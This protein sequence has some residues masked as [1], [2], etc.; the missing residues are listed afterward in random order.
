MRDWPMPETDEILVS[1]LKDKRKESLK[2][3][4]MHSRARGQSGSKKPL[5]QVKHS[6][7]IHDAKEAEQLVVKLA[8]SGTK[9]SEI[10][11][12]LRDSYGI[13]DVKTITNKKVGDILKEN[14]LVKEIPE[15]LLCVIRRDIV[16]M[17]HLDANKKDLSAKRGMI[18]TESKIHRL[19]KYYIREGKLPKDWKYDRTKA[20]VL[21][22]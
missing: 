21:V 16:I 2:M 18:L 11:M 12:I 20:K 22:E 1:H 15:D 17:K 9:Q 14:K 13:P 7:V 10:G 5:K 8:K 4:K 3:A 19:S 6:W